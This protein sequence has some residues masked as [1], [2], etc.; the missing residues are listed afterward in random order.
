MPTQKSNPL[1]SIITPSYN[2]VDFIEETIQSVL[3]QDYPCKEFIIVDGG[4]TDGTIAIL[5]KYSTQ[6]TWV[7]G[8][9]RGQ[10]NAINKGFRMSTGEILFW[11][12]SDDVLL[13]GAITRIVD[14]FTANPGTKFVYGRSYFTDE[15][16]NIIGQYPT[17]P[18]NYSRL[19]MFNFISQ[20]SAFFTRD[21]FYGA[22]EL[23]ESLSY[24]MD[25][26][27][28]IRISKKY[29]ALYLPEYLSNNRLHDTSKT[30]DDLQALP[31][32]KET[33]DTAFKH[34]GWAPANRVYGYCYQLAE[35]FA[36]K[37]F[38]GSKP[39]IIGLALF[40][41]LI[42]YLQLNKGIRK[43]DIQLLNWRYVKKMG[44]RWNEYYK[45]Y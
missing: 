20:P 5:Q 33:L 6:L 9:D 36:Q 45:T 18:F 25:Y 3:S 13:P 44:L 39:V 29:N 10:T 40:L 14:C 34:Y 37:F 26:D 19:A 12:N 4:S 7:S 43:A 27:L 30:M 2:Q 21:A 24:T 35:P 28:W 38:R 17:E 1:I 22:G 16:G 15:K 41:S 8:K 42:K 23:D 31:N 11:I 32:S